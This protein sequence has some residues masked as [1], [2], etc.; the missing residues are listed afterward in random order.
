M[1]TR[2]G[3][4]RLLG[5][6]V[7]AAALAAAPGTA[8]ADEVFFAGSTGGAFNGAASG[9]TASLLGLVFD[10]STFSGTTSAGFLG[11]GSNAAAGSNVNN[12][13]SFTLSSAAQNYG[14][15]SNTFSLLVTFSAPAGI[16]GGQ[17]STYTATVTGS[18]AGQD[19]GGVKLDFDNTPKTFAFSNGQ[20]NN[21]SFSF[22][23]NDVSIEAGHVAPITGTIQSAALTAIP[24][25][26]SIALL[27]SGL[28]GLGVAVRRRSRT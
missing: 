18:V 14:S 2:G 17:A 28:A 8:R 25:P 3:W 26:A 20:G 16:E 27:G 4:A 23:V 22:S 5:L 24:E 12:L 10:N 19:N 13:G 11:I 6:G 21:G 7:A 9:S 1:R 15:G